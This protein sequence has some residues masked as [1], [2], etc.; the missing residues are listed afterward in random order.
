MASD[1]A[2]MTWSDL[3]A[4]AK[5]FRLAHAAW[6]VVGM[7]TLAYIWWSALRRRRDRLLSASVAFLLLEGIAL[8]VG[9]GNCPFGP[10]Q[11]RLGDPVPLFELVLPPRAAKAAIPVLT[12]VTL[13]GMAAAAMRG[14]LRQAERSSHDLWHPPA[15]SHHAEERI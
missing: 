6:G 10:L 13:T 1:Q 2:A 9:R 12:V 8:I 14:P 5:A 7:A 11:T 15:L 3:G 4:E